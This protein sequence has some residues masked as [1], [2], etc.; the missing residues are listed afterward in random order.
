MKNKK[1]AFITVEDNSCE[2]S[3]VIAFP[4]TW[5]ENKKLLVKGNTVLIIGERSKK[6][7]SF[8]VQRVSQI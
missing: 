2:L 1:M 5:E 3:S 6:K 7:D 4:E 8:I